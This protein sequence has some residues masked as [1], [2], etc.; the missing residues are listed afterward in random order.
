[1]KSKSDKDMISTKRNNI[2]LEGLINYMINSCQKPT[3]KE[4]ILSKINLST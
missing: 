2:K 3:M 1:M 4:K